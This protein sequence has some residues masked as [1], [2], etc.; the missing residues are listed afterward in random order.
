MED[1]KQLTA[2]CEKLVELKKKFAED[3][4]A[5][6][7]LKKKVFKMEQDD[8]PT[9]MQEAGLESMKLSDGSSVDVVPDFHCGISAARMKDAVNWLMKTKNQGIIKVNV[10]VDF[11]RGDIKSAAALAK[12]NEG[13]VVKHSI[14]PATLKA[15]LREEMEK[16]HKVPLKT[17]GI[18]EFYR[19]KVKIPKA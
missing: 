17:F 9:A 8:I 4:A 3:E 1:L 10:S 16:G 6:A 13:A 18:D 15:F 19:V 5:L 7:E 12:K 11:D 14:H 2:L